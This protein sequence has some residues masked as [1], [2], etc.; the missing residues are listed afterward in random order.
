MEGLTQECKCGKVQ[1]ELTG[2]PKLHAACCC[3][4]CRLSGEYV[5]SRGGDSP[6][7]VVGSLPTAFFVHN[8][9]K[10]IKGKDNIQAFVV[11][12]GS[13]TRRFYCKSC[14]TALAMAPAG[15]PMIGLQTITLKSNKSGTWPALEARHSLQQIKSKDKHDKMVVDCQNDGNNVPWHEE[16]YAPCFQFL[17]PVICAAICCSK[18]TI[19][20]ITDVDYLGISEVAVPGTIDCSDSTN[21]HPIAMQAI[22]R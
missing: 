9:V 19:P 21:I 1:F 22:S 7:D 14:K 17:C 12:A 11:I 15:F 10:L 20:E 2:Q 18:S 6:L 13:K 4:G 5:Q 16:Q 3:N 8:D